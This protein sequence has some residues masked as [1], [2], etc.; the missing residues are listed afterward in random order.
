[1]N[2]LKVPLYWYL[3]CNQK[4]DILPPLDSSVMRRK[5][6]NICPVSDF[7]FVVAVYICNR[8]MPRKAHASSSL[9]I[10]QRFLSGR[11]EEM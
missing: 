8:Y 2:K 11:V 9:F 3:W 4:S 1:M 6:V 7:F 5:H 10:H